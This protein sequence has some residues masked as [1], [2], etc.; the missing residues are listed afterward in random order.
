ML[1]Y[2]LVLYFSILQCLSFI[3]SNLLMR[4]KCHRIDETAQTISQHFS[5]FLLALPHLS[6][7]FTT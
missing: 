4:S 7:L 3:M 6:P 1:K 5:Y 2:F